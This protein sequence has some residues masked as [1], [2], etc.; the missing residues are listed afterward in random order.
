MTIACLPRFLDRLG[1]SASQA[2]LRDV[3]A[4]F[5][6]DPSLMNINAHVEQ[7]EVAI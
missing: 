2:A 5:D 3:L 1:E 4:L 7:K 6:A